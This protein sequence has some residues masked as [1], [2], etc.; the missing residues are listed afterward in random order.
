VGFGWWL[1]VGG[2]GGGGWGEKKFAEFNGSKNSFQLATPPVQFPVS[3]NETSSTSNV[4]RR[5]M[6]VCIWMNMKG[7]LK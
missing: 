5:R 2:G 3:F 1:G 6:A 4:M 7:R